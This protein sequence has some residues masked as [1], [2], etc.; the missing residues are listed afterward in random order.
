MW[1]SATP[2]FSEALLVASA[3][4]ILAPEIWIPGVSWD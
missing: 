4:H 1:D 2:E 3:L